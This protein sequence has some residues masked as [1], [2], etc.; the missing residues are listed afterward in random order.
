MPD[1]PHPHQPPQPRRQQQPAAGASRFIGA[2]FGLAFAGVGLAVIGGLWFGGMGDPPIIFKLVGSFIATIFVAVGGT[3]A[4]G[5][6]TGA[7]P[8]SE[9]GASTSPPTGTAPTTSPP[10]GSRTYT[11]PHCGGGL[12]RNADVSPMGDVKCAFCG[13][14]FNVHGRS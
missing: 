14:W 1:S 9:Q 2:V 12:D 8:M 5:A 4:F 6:I 10:A 11:C 7:G 13:R 3:L